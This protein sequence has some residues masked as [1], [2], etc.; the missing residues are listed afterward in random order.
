MLARFHVA[1]TSWFKL[2][3]TRLAGERGLAVALVVIDRVDAG[4]A[5][6]AR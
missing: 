6:L 1:L 2:D 3:F 4:A 5:I